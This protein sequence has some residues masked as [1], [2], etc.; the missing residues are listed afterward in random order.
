M[1]PKDRTQEVR[2]ATPTAIPE[3]SQEHP[4]DIRPP[5]ARPTGLPNRRE[6][7]GSSFAP[8]TGTARTPGTHP[9]E[10]E[11]QLDVRSDTKPRPD[12]G[13]ASPRYRPPFRWSGG[14]RARPTRPLPRPT[15]S[16]HCL[17]VGGTAVGR[18]A[19]VP[20]ARGR[21]G[22][23]ERRVG[24]GSSRCRRSEGRQGA[25]GASAYRASPAPFRRGRGIRRFAIHMW[26]APVHNFSRPDAE[27]VAEEVVGVPRRGA[28]PEARAGDAV[29]GMLWKQPSTRSDS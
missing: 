22:R 10:P 13:W 5:P 19:P 15:A 9:T 29:L 11:P 27:E 16:S 7:G 28:V 25:G 18:R 23:E 17:V 26:I 3:A 21:R 1:D 12:I 4:R 2:E 20:P 24:R 14:E 6:A 8:Q